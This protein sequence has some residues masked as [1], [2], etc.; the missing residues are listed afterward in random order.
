MLVGMIA[1]LPALGQG[2]LNFYNSGSATG[3]TDG[4]NKITD[5]ATGLQLTGTGYWAQLYF[6]TTQTG[7]YTALGTPVNFRTAA[8]GTTFAGVVL[9]PTANT[10]VPGSPAGSSVWVV[11]KAWEGAAGST[12]DSVAAANGKIGASNPLLVGPLGGPNPAGGTDILPANLTGFTGFAI[13]A[14]PE[15]STIAL[16]LLGAAG[17]LI[18]RR[19]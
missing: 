1:A 16:G 18:R 10:I 17:L 3:K 19:K 8:Q 2:S 6:S 11:M 4:S 15:P 13:V 5:A 9:A 7:N 14:V 12:Y